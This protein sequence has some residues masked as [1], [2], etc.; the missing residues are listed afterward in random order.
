MKLAHL[1]ELTNSEI[2]YW[3]LNADL[4]EKGFS[5]FNRKIEILKLADKLSNLYPRKTPAIEYFKTYRINQ[6]NNQ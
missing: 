5:K 3:A 1:L 4:F 2:S 6:L